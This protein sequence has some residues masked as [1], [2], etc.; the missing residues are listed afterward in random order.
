MKYLFILGM[1]GSGKTKLAEHI[2]EYSPKKFKKAVQNTT[3]QPRPT[4]EPGHEY[5]F[6]NNEEYDSSSHSGEM[7]GQVR[8]EFFPARYGTNYSELD[9][10]KTN[11]VVLSIEGFIDAF[12][13]LNPKDRVSVIFIKD[14]QPE[15]QRE[16]RDNR[17]EEKYNSIVLHTFQR[18]QYDLP[19]SKMHR[20]N[21]V[22]IKHERLKEIRDSKKEVL[23]FLRN[24]N[25]K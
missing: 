13:K 3:R 10:K 23:T 1:S 14:V 18:A 9:S 19:S 17:S 4:E 8:E 6:L 16:N 15:V 7:L 12:F 25:I 24:N 2:Q 5:Y 20:F 11:I 22:E 21:L